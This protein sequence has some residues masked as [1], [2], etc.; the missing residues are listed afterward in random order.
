MH[1]PLDNLLTNTPYPGLRP[2][3][4]DEADI[5]FG[6][7]EQV[8]QLLTRLEQRRFL[9]VVGVSGCGKSSLVR[10]G[11]LSALERGFLSAAGPRWQVAE[12]R[13]GN[14]PL[15]NLAQALLA[16]GRLGG[17][18]RDRPDARSFLLAALRRGPLGLVELLRESPDSPPANL[19]LL[20]DQ[21][22]EI[23]RFHRHG[24]P[25]E[26]TAFVDLLLASAEQTSLPVYVTIT[27]RSDFLGDCSI[28]TGLPE[29]INAGEF[30]IPRLTRAQCRAAIVG[31]A[32]AFGATVD[33]ALVT[34][35]LNDT[36]TDPD[37][38]PLIQHAL[39]RMWNRGSAGA[40]G[41]QGSEGRRLTVEDYESV[42]GLREALSNHADEL[43]AGLDSRQQR[44]AE[45]LM[46]SLSERG[47]DQRDTR[48]PVPLRTV[49]AVAR[50]I[51]ESVARVVEVFRQTDCSFLTPPVGVPIEAETILDIGHESLI[52]Q[53][54]RMSDWVQAEADSASIYRRLTETAQ[55]WKTGQAALWTTPDLENALSWRLREEPNAPWAQ[56]YGGH[57]EES[58]AFLDASLAARDLRLGEEAARR[59]RELK[60]LADKAQAEKLRADEADARRLEQI[61]ANRRL[62][63]RAITA[64]SAGLVSIAL[65]VVA[66]VL[67]WRARTE[68]DRA[69]AS[70]GE[71]VQARRQAERSAEASERAMDREKEARQEAEISARHMKQSQYEAVSQTLG[72]YASL[73]QANLAQSQ[74][75]WSA[76]E[77]GRQ[78]KALELLEDTSRLRSESLTLLPE[79]GEDLAGAL[80]RLAAQWGELVP[81][82][83][84]QAV[85]WLSYTSLQPI[86]QFAASPQSQGLPLAL[87]P[88]GKLLALYESDRQ[89][90]YKG[91]YLLVD[92]R[93][94]G[95]ALRLRL[96]DQEFRQVAALAFS[97]DGSTLLTVATIPSQA[98]S[99]LVVE[100]RSTSD[101]RVQESVALAM[102]AS[103][104]AVMAGLA[105]D[106]RFNSQASRVASVSQTGGAT[107]WEVESGRLLR[108]AEGIRWMGWNGAGDQVVGMAGNTVRLVEMEEGSAPREISLSSEGKEI[109]KV[110]CSPDDRWLIVQLADEYVLGGYA[111]PFRIVEV[112]TG[113]IVGA[114]HL[115]SEG[116]GFG[117]LDSRN[118][119][120]GFHFS[121]RMMAVMN[122]KLVYLVTL[123]GGEILYQTKVPDLNPTAFQSWMPV[124]VEFNRDGSLLTTAARVQLNNQEFRVQFWDPAAGS[125]GAQSRVFPTS[126][127]ACE[128]LSAE[129][130]ALA[131][132]DGAAV[133]VEVQRP[134][135]PRI[136][137]TQLGTEASGFEPSGA[138]FVQALPGRADIFDATTGAQVQSIPRSRS[139][140]GQGWGISSDFRWIVGLDATRDPAEPGVFDAT[141]QTWTCRLPGITDLEAAATYSPDGRMIA[142]RE[143]VPGAGGGQTQSF[144]VVYRL[145]DGRQ[146]LSLDP[147]Y[148]ELH[149]DR[150]ERVVVSGYRTNQVELAVFHLDSGRELAKHLIPSG[151]FS[152][153][154]GNFWLVPNGELAVFTLSQESGRRRTQVWDVAR[155]TPPQT[156]PGEFA[157]GQKVWLTN[158]RLVVMG[159]ST[160]PQPGTE[161]GQPPSHVVRLFDLQT[162]QLLLE[163]RDA[164]P[165]K[166]F[167]SREW[168]LLVIARVEPNGEGAESSVYDLESGRAVGRVPEVVE[169]L[170]PNG[171]LALTLRGTLYDLQAIAQ[172][173]E[174]DAEQPV[175]E[176]EPADQVAPLANSSWQRSR[177]SPDS[178]WL[179]LEGTNTTFA[180]RRLSQSLPFEAGGTE[181]R[182]AGELQ[183]APSAD[184][185]RLVSYD[186]ASGRVRIRAVED[187][188]VQAEIPLQEGILQSLGGTTAVDAIDVSS[189]GAQFAIKAAERWRL[190]NAD[191]DRLHTQLPRSSHDQ[192]VWALDV[193]REAGIVASA[194]EDRTVCFWD[195]AD[196]RFLGMLE[197][198]GSTLVAV[199][200]HPT[201]PLVAT[202]N[203]TGG[204][205]V[206]RWTLE[207][208]ERQRRIVAEYV[209]GN[210]DAVGRALRFS[211]D[212]DNLV[213]PDSHG[214][215]RFFEAAT[216]TLTGVLYPTSELG[217]VQGLAYEPG[218]ERLALAG[219]R[220]TIALWNRR[221]Q[222]W[223]RQWETG[224]SAVR[225]L[226]YSPDGRLLVSAGN[227]IRVWD[228]ASGDLLF[229]LDRQAQPVTDVAI[230]PSGRWL[231]SL[232]ED[233]TQFVLNLEDLARALDQMQV[234]WEADDPLVSAARRTPQ[235]ASPEAPLWRAATSDELAVERVRAGHNWSATRAE[236]ILDWTEAARQLRPLC[237]SEPNN[238]NYRWRLARALG[239]TQQWDEAEAAWSRTAE[240]TPDD[241]Y[242]YYGRAIAALGARRLGDYRRHVRS[243]LERFGK[244]Q[245]ADHASRALYAA[246]PIHGAVEETATLVPLS[247]I[248][249]HPRLKGAALYRDGQYAEAI[250]Q[251]VQQEMYGARAWDMLFLSMAYARTGQTDEA[252]KLLEAAAG[253]LQAMEANASAE[254]PELIETRHLYQEAQALLEP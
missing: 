184:G 125:V 237:E 249:Q 135:G 17:D 153:L 118:E 221:S 244:T 161:P 150:S 14:H 95:V 38:L 66:I 144:L 141:S 254:W 186:P 100:S 20:V 16:S 30:L 62:R 182:V 97:S 236:R 86:G 152:G 114:C 172:R 10:A 113:R 3:R 210:F 15:S 212:G 176:I 241:P 132:G 158:T 169:S 171:R 24:D 200:F 92:T 230:D 12:M 46:R 23:F 52:R 65:A 67:F 104:P 25:N 201:E 122:G 22:E 234:G 177:F 183:P 94:G 61:A 88:D 60:L 228:A 146:M 162:K 43:Y 188:S 117:M 191:A 59:E 142:V 35:I 154:S 163:R 145:E 209:W 56:R 51:P 130:L 116:F 193:Q 29:A 227:S 202:R 34:R 247:E 79:L 251:L 160:D 187:G 11:M 252:R 6:R 239:E 178:R 223:D 109:R 21:F 102:P 68:R 219:G 190:G 71:A 44:I 124:L 119:R 123:P 2:F 246:V 243:L 40:E 226:A 218:G 49:A 127:R 250:E 131:G 75:L 159:Q 206:W 69:D 232:A 106:F 48:R 107:V 220:S 58:M 174:A 215:I 70:R 89:N 222:S 155:Q 138:R 205:T 41:G 115:P 136:W 196:G 242:P 207:E 101:L 72:A 96:G 225:D 143:T 140:T 204:L 54:K 149:F 9:A 81:R 185:R 37:Q 233:R 1:D 195:A 248:A 166:M 203:E 199:Q 112:A 85:R 175:A 50:E 27:M 105:V 90:Y 229:A 108:V 192:P 32:A 151:G 5:F 13:P 76:A 77:S 126:A 47:S 83:R 194:G 180:M 18:W 57:F 245:N 216:G 8:D 139:A 157:F 82:I 4:R 26:A 224:Q 179:L 39:M 91:T 74:S 148:T 78:Q 168:N 137:N 120:V 7:D 147:A 110:T 28:F 170:S 181:V 64:L 80:P 63:G 198:F 211:P 111:M 208:F 197:G 45:V 19:L 231:A 33:E 84:S 214:R 53:W 133:S 31:P 235:P 55:L 173:K 98:A 164:N 156:L 253:A 93:T 189:N 121:G 167:V 134:T 238:A 42:G 103:G 99:S 213:V 128:F 129:A 87:S 73:A 36:G 165:Q 217:V 240:L